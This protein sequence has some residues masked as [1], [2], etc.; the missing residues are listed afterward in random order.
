MSFSWTPAGLTF[1]LLFS[2]SFSL[3]IFLFLSF[4]AHLHS[5]STLI[6]SSST[7]KDTHFL[8]SDFQSLDSYNNSINPI[9]AGKKSASMGKKT[10]GRSVNFTSR[11]FLSLDSSNDSRNQFETG[12]K[13]ASK[14]IKIIGD[15]G[16]FTSLDFISLDS[17]GRRTSGD[18]K[19][20]CD[21]FNGT[22]V[23]DDSYPLYTNHSCFFIDD[24]FNC[25]A[26]GRPDRDYMK[27]RWKPNGCDIPR[28]YF[29]FLSLA[30][31]LS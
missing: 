13:S 7:S 22:W 5:T 26:N 31:S 10:T 4:W 21:L 23:F 20:S 18:H 12:E 29:V 6:I 14:K 2:F 17:T 30:P 8:V 19:F 3:L 28:Y 16:N 15:I 11:D 1:S 24:G 27:W 25:E 9:E